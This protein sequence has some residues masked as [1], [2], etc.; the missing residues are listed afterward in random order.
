MAYKGKYSYQE[1]RLTFEHFSF[2][3]KKQK[4]LHW[5]RSPLLL[6]TIPMAFEYQLDFH[7]KQFLF[8]FSHLETEE[9]QYSQRMNK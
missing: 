1:F 2:S 4:S 5:M 3:L 7:L 6:A 8:N 9:I